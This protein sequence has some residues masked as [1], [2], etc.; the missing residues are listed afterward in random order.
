MRTTKLGTLTILLLL[1]AAVARPA[2]PVILAGRAQQAKEQEPEKPQILKPPIVKLDAAIEETLA[3][4]QIIFNE[5]DRIDGLAG[6]ALRIPISRRE[7]VARAEAKAQKFQAWLKEHGIPQ[8]WQASGWRFD[9]QLKQFFP[10]PENKEVKKDEKKDE[11]KGPQP[12]A[13]QP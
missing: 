1:F 11:K 13:P 10:P 5:I 4:R 12:S 3:D 7:L 9:A 2:R 6:D 8:D